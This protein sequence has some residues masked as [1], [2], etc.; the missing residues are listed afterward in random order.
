MAT[1]NNPLSLQDNLCE[2]II[3]QGLFSPEQRVLAMVSGGADSVF[4]L[5]LLERLL[6]KG[7]VK[8]LGVFHFNHGLYPTQND[9][10]EAFVKTLCNEKNLPCFCAKGDTLAQCKV[11]GQSIE[12]CA[13]TLRYAAA[14]QTLSKEGYDV[15]ATAHNRDDQ[16]E[17]I[18][19]HLLRGCGIG[20]LA[21]MRERWQGIVRPL[22]GVGAK[23]LRSWLGENH[24][25]YVVDKSNSSPAFLRNRIRLELVG[26]LK[27]LSPAIDDHL[28]RL[29]ERA[30]EHEDFME[31]SF[32]SLNPQQDIPFKGALSVEAA[33]FCALAPYVQS[34]VLLQMLEVLRERFDIPQAAIKTALKKAGGR[35]STFSCELKK[36]SFVLPQLRIYRP[37]QKGAFAQRSRPCPDPL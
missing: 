25:P 8:S 28:C 24:I 35:E 22:L 9:A 4:L 13:R 34:G 18:L 6:Q 12:A 11:S 27:E 31:Q 19:L 21:G 16:S 23:E 2:A 33:A 30:R 20:A 29:A 10:H 1:E 14:R 37:C 3:R 26:K 15:L 5:T 32:L 36:R 17:T 7:A